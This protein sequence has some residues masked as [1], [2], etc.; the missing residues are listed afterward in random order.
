MLLQVTPD[1]VAGVKLVGCV[2][3]TGVA[4]A[5]QK[6]EFKLSQIN[7]MMLATNTK[8]IQKQAL[9]YNKQ[10]KP[11]VPTA[12]SRGQLEVQVQL[13]VVREALNVLLLK[14]NKKNDHTQANKSFYS[15][16]K[17]QSKVVVFFTRI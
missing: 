3:R 12:G 14:Q 11:F 8:E 17:I 13:V 15:N 16:F 6:Q 7:D 5:V 10:V 9:V 2:E 4:T 1:P